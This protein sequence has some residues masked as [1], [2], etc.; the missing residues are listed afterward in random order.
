MQRFLIFLSACL[1][2]SPFVGAQTP[3]YRSI[4]DQQG[5]P[6]N[7]IYDIF[8]DEKGYLWMGTETGMYRYDGSEFHSFRQKVAPGQALTGIT[9]VNGQIYAFDFLGHVFQNR[10]DS[11]ISMPMDSTVLKS[12]YV[13]L[14]DGS[15]GRLYLSSDQGLFRYDEKEQKW[16]DNTPA[17]LGKNYPSTI[18]NLQREADALWFT[19][20]AGIIKTGPSGTQA[21]P[22]QLKNGKETEPTRYFLETGETGTWLYHLISGKVYRLE[23]ER[24][25]RYEDK[26]LESLLKDKK[27]TSLREVNGKLYIMSFSGLV[28]HDLHSHKSEWIFRGIPITAIV[29]DF[30]GSLWMSTLGYG[31]IFCPS[32]EFRTWYQLRSGTQNK[33]THFAP[34]ANGGLLFSR[35]IGA[36]GLISPDGNTV[37]QTDLPDQTDI[38][39]LNSFQNGKVYLTLNSE[40]YE[41]QGMELIHVPR[42][43]PATKDLYGCEL[44]I[45]IA[46]ST[47]VHYRKNMQETDYQKL[48]SC[49]A[50]RI[51][52]E[53]SSDTI[54]V[55][56]TSGLLCLYRNEVVDTLFEG[57]GVQDLLWVEE[58][59]SLYCALLSGRIY[60]V[61]RGY[62]RL[63]RQFSGNGKQVYRMRYL[64]GYLWLASSH[65]LGK[66]HTTNQYEQWYTMLDGL[67]SNMLYDLY[68]HQGHWWLATGNGLQQI[69]ADLRKKSSNPRLYTDRIRI[70]YQDQSQ[71]AVLELGAS[72]ELILDFDVLSYYSQGDFHLAY[73]FG[74]NI[75]IHLPKGQR[76][77]V[78][79]AFPENYEALQVMAID[80]KGEASEPV[81]F[82]LNIHPPY[83][84]RP[85]FILLL[86][87][88][89]AGIVSLIHASRLKGIQ[90]R[91]ADVLEKEK[92]R[93]NLIESQLTALKAQMNPHFIFNSLNSIYEL[94]LF[95]ESREAATYL[96]KFAVLL[97][98]VLENSEKDNIPLT[99]EC[100][101]LELYLQLEKL[102]FGNDFTYSVNTEEV[103]DP[104]NHTLPTMLLQPFVEN[105]VK[106]GLLHK[107]GIKRLEVE[108]RTQG[109]WLICKISDNGVGRTKAGQYQKQKNG[110]H[111]SF[112][113]GAIQR[114]IDMLNRSGRYHIDLDVED[115]SYPSGKPAGTQVELRMKSW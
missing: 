114:R 12:G 78:I 61:S 98:K 40:V 69:P 105:A 55:G 80:A 103:D 43:F 2:L 68:Y 35:Y 17:I 34:T 30:E 72:D 4:T 31:L 89:V 19:S 66:I 13:S 79:S 113:T 41:V 94:I 70:R 67:S 6:C 107:D 64:R 23:G 44:G 86:I 62:P 65:G 97:R 77:L 104:Y 21:Y 71:D 26:H 101:W 15:D 10:G 47:G 39:A 63:F 115:L 59:K 110:D 60:R 84:Q 24:F 42:N 96:N 32:L 57:E 58:E 38:S 29:V 92:L 76:E 18:K 111:R 87:G 28:V 9:S 37:I 112:A 54:W 100:E 11:L 3:E 25:V 48:A 20:A 5:L 16:R 49:W 73:S 102:R 90:K 81:I 93:S 36:M 22:I 99:E 56:T 52:R 50:K 7:E 1:W 51:G 45:Y 88:G 53:G 108:F 75:W 106:H 83:W 91:Q 95:S 8:F 46:S 85:W 27:F 82:A 109:D 14:S 74:N 33:Y